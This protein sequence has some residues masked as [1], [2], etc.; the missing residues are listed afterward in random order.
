MRTRGV[1]HLCSWLCGRD[2]VKNLCPGSLMK[3]DIWCSSWK[4]RVG[5]R[6]YIAIFLLD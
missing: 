5:D 2:F 1:R 6:V 3:A 4:L